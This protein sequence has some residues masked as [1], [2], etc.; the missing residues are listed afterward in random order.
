[1]AKP[2]KVTILGDVSDLTK[3]LDDGEQAVSGFGVSLGN[4]AGKVAG[5]AAKFALV[6]GAVAGIGT[7][8]SDA[9]AQESLTDKLNAQLGATGAQAKTYGAAAGA[10]Y[11]KG[12]GESMADIT[13]AIRGVVQNIDGMSTASQAE[14]QRIGAKASDTA[15]IFDQDL[16]GVTRAVGQMIRTGLAA[17]ADEAFDIIVAGFQRGVDKSGDFLDTLNEYGTMFRALGLDGQTAT[18]LLSQGLQAGARDADKVADALKEFAIRAKDGSKT[19]SD[20]F[21][22]IGLSASEMAGKFAAGGPVAAAALDLTLDRLRAIPDPVKRSTAAVNL[23]GTQAEDLQ[24]ALYALDPSTAVAG[25]G[26]VSGAAAAAGNTLHDNA[27]AKLEAFGRTLSS[28]L[29]TVLGTYVVPLIEKV[30]GVLAT[31]LGPALSVA[32]GILTST[33]IPALTSLVDWVGRNADWLSV[34]AGI[35]TAVFLPALVAMGVQATISAAQTVAAWTVS[36][37]QAIA[38]L[39][40]QSAALVSL[41]A[42]WVGLGLQSLMQSARVAAAW[43][44]SKVQAAASLAG[45]MI[46]FVALGAAWVGLGVQA[47]IQGARIAGAWVLSKVEALASLAAQVPA[48]AVLVAG[49]VALGVQSL[50]RGAQMAAA[51]VMAMGPIGWIIAAV[52]GLVALIIANWDTVKQWTIDAWNAVVDFIVSAG[53]NIVRTVTE[54]FN[55]VVDKVRGAYNWVIDIW[56]GI[57][58]FFFNLGGDIRRAIGDAFDWVVSKIRGAIQW[59]QDRISDVGNFLSSINPF[60]AMGGPISATGV[61]TVGERGPEQVLLPKGAQVIPNHAAA[62]G[63]SG[64]GAVVNVYAQTNANPYAIGREVAWA[65]RTGGR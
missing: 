8:I 54:H 48:F 57:T 24:D 35:I 19:T 60:R 58:G 59:I 64:N 31:V 7:A 28:G 33:V 25:L 41:S 50:I 63:G 6:S 11:A 15:K 46:A 34:V 53:R 65:M 4:V 62:G 42:L 32:A 10:L 18:G 21:A 23:F 12:Y 44:L 52:V 40:T 56:S 16:G 55:W 9:I 2:I 5:M 3:K 13:E 37:V 36:K 38:S 43:V 22:A 47:A 1:M 61:Y 49:W 45:Q 27:Q 29:V 17:N 30:A 26:Q 51:W 20:G 14:L 39:V